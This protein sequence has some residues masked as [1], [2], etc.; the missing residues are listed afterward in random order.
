MHLPFGHKQFLDVF[1]AYN[2]AF[3]WAALLLWLATAAVAV[4]WLRH[5][6]RAGRP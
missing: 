5:P 3:W 1:G 6:S 2:R 4:R